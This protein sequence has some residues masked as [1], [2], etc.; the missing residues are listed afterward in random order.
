MLASSS[1]SDSGQWPNFPRSSS[2]SAVSSLIDSCKPYQLGEITNGRQYV[3]VRVLRS[4]E[5]EIH[6]FMYILYICNYTVAIVSNQ[7]CALHETR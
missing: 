7:L 2:G 4:T 6:C 1:A 5:I 3:S